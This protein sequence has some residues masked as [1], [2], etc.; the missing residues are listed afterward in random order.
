MKNSNISVFSKNLIKYR[1]INNYTQESLALK[2]D[3]TK[4]SIYSYEKGESYPKLEFI[5]KVCELFN[6]TP[7]DLLLENKEESFGTDKL[8]LSKDS[9]TRKDIAINI[10]QCISLESFFNYEFKDKNDPLYPSKINHLVSLE[11]K[12]SEIVTLIAEYLSNQKINQID[13]IKTA[14]KKLD[15][16]NNLTNITYSGVDE[17]F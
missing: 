17:E 7:N 12:D 14:Q 3:T 13:A 9:V 8:I 15:C 1:K 10:L 11:V 6:I 16:L 5:Y 4:T 2:L